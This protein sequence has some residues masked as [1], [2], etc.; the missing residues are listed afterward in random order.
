MGRSV[1][2]R[3]RLIAT[4]LAKL[5]ALVALVV[6]TNNPEIGDTI[7]AKTAPNNATVSPEEVTKQATSTLVPKPTATPVPPTVTPVPKPT[8][9]HM[10]SPTPTQIPGRPELYLEA[11]VPEHLAYTWWRWD[12]DRQFREV[13]FDFTIRN[14]PGNFSGD[15]GL[16]LMVC[17]GSISNHK[18]YFGLQTNVNDPDRRGGRGKGLIFSRWD[19]RDPNFVRVAG[20]GDGW[21]ESSGYE[22]NFISVRRS[23][24]WRAGPYR[25][26]LAPDDLDDNG[27]W[28][29]LWITDL[30]TDE[31]VWVGSLKF[32]LVDGATAVKPPL[33]SVLEIYG[34]RHIRP[35][36][37]PEWRVTIKRPQGDGMKASS[38]SRGYSGL[39]RFS[40]PN[41][42]I[43]YDSDADGFHFRIGGITEQVGGVEPIRFR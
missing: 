18:F 13:I 10:P 32:P 22:G 4:V 8:T 16:Y 40:K 30:N 24:D 20:E 34:R 21:Y 19:E 29:G 3:A 15:Y 39:G 23:Y 11:A 38:G 35:I 25:M 42:D 2:P 37:I 5:F 43:Q 9:T 41:A 7:E 26:R 31:T 14:D 36:D 6:C 27:E 28:F 17:F 1:Q 12:G 33:A